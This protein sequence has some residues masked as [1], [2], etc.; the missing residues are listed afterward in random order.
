MLKPVRFLTTY[1]HTQGLYNAGEVA[2]FA[3]EI[4]DELVRRGVAVELDAPV[5][6]AE[7]PAAEPEAPARRTRK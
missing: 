1:H 6:A 7:A 3:P 2:G 5:K 4:S